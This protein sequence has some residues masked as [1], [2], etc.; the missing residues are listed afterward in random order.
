MI[1]LT[2]ETI[3]EGSV[4]DVERVYAETKIVPTVSLSEYYDS[5][6][7]ISPKS[8]LTDVEYPWDF[9]TRLA[10]D[11]QMIN[12][13]RDIDAA[14]SVGAAGTV[15]VNNTDIS[16]ITTNAALN[17]NLDGWIGRVVPRAKLKISDT[18]L[19]TPELPA[20]LPGG[21]A[22]TESDIF[23]RGVQLSRANTFSN[24]ASVTGEYGF[25]P[26]IG[27]AG[28]YSYSLFRVGQ[29]FLATPNQVTATFTDSNIHSFSGGPKFQL[30]RSETLSLN[31]QNMFMSLSAPGFQQSFELHG[32]A[33][34]YSKVTPDWTATISGGATL[35]NPGERVF[36]TGRATLVGKYDPLTT[37]TIVA[38]RGAAPA[39]FG[40]PGALI[41]TS[42]SAFLSKE[43]T[44]TLKL[45]ASGNYAL[46]ESAPVEGQAK[47]VSYTASINLKYDITRTVFSEL[48]YNYTNFM[49]GGELINPSLLIERN[50]L[51]LS[52]NKTWK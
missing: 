15:F 19:F 45:T 16:F 28:T 26:V 49:M 52:I 2:A 7:F 32:G 30:T 4:N 50:L 8:F 21:R 3:L 27:L 34:E 43:L 39:I 24:I 48:N 6:V 37:V 1:L 10:S 31:Y 13:S 41:S 23:A 20:F 51:M 17:A 35:I 18:F 14:A 40:V 25:T 5:N 46:N 12:T 44:R 47:F 11:V 38:S 36:L 33:I 9:G 29:I 22:A 42:A